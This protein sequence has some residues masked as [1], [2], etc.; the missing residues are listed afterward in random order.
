VPSATKIELTS[1]KDHGGK[2]N[3]RYKATARNGRVVDDSEEGLRNRAYALVK[4]LRANP[5]V[6]VIIINGVQLTPEGVE[7]AKAKALA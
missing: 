2:V 1:K 3:W 7:A 6:K 5:D 4:A